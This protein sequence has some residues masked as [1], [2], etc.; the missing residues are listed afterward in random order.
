MMLRSALPLALLFA[1]LAAN[2]QTGDSGFTEDPQKLAQ[3][4][5]LPTGV[6]L[7]K[8]AVASASDSVTPL[9]EGGA[10]TRDV[11]RN[12][13]L[14]L[15]YALPGGW[16][17]KYQGP[18]PSDSGSYVLAQLRPG[19]KYQGA[20]KGTL[21]ITAQD[22]LF[23]RLP[24]TNAMEL[25]QAIHDTL[26]K[27]I[28]QVERPPAAI[29]VAGRSFGRFDYMSPSAQLHWAVLA[30]EIRCHAVRFVFTS[31]DPA[32]VESLIGD[33]NKMTL[34]EHAGATTGTGGGEAPLCVP[35]YADKHATY[36]VSPQ[37]GERR[38]NAIPVRVIIGKT[39]K[40]KHVHMLS[41]FPDQAKAITDALLQWRFAPYLQ[42]GE[43][44]E[45]E[46]GIMFGQAPQAPSTTAKVAKSE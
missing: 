20:S 5:K 37:F 25:I 19:P 30:T 39:G 15:S 28:Y 18:P 44:V 36:K 2:A 33:M 3:L 31:P 1:C 10:I 16:T 32:L 27:P 24:A 7:V 13:Y 6:I 42:N 14:G 9:P 45:V 12:A 29:T 26:Q 35:N 4:R 23:T 11:Y 41:A 8:G 46:T 43:P 17:Q 40:V 22:L 34:P 38:F 21:L